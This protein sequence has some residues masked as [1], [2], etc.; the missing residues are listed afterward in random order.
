MD[1]TLQGSLLDLADEMSLRDLGDA[2]RRHHLTRGA[3][4][5]VRPDWLAA[6]DALFTALL[7]DVP[8]HAERRQMYDSVVDVPRLTK[9]Y[10]AGERLPHPLL[11]TAREALSAHY[12]DELGEPFVT[13]GL[14]LYRD[15]RDS[16][17]WH[18]DRIGRSRDSDTMI[19]ILSLGSSR[20]LTLR[21]RD[22]GPI[23]GTSQKS[24]RFPLGH[25]DLVVMGGSCQ[26]TW[27][28]AVPKTS[29]PVGPRISVQFRVSGVR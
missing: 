3:W 15:G 25:G 2:T 18:G 1:L 10:A 14:C 27:D 24:L 9:F 8:W 17:A 29:E 16:V 19:A 13:A 28:H 26:R 7:H 4:V 22:G 11:T 12:A 20:T 6:G 21:P 23:A 5:D